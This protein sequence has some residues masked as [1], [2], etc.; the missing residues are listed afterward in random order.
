M[1]AVAAALAGLAGIWWLYRREGRSLSFGVRLMLA[2]LRTLI[3]V[4]VCF[5]LL[6]MVVVISRQE[7]IPSRLLV[8]LD[9]SESMGLKD[10][11]TDDSTGAKPPKAWT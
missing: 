7:M 9:D 1:L 3:L 2:A 5:M 10:A 11:W 8:L 4:G 6:E